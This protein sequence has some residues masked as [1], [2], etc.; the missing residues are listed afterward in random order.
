MALRRRV[1]SKHTERYTVWDNYE[2]HCK[3]LKEIGAT[4]EDLKPLKEAAEAV[5]AAEEQ[6]DRDKG[7][8]PLL[9]NTDLA[10][11][12]GPHTCVNG[13]VVQPPTRVARRWASSA[14]MKVTGGEQ[15][16]DALGTAYA[17]LAGLWALKAWGD[18]RKDEVMQVV[19]GPGRLAELLPDLEA[20]AGSTDYDALAGDYSALM[21]FSKK[22][23]AAMEKY[24]TILASIR[25][26]LSD[27]STE[28]S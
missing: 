26:K 1:T 9:E 27:R 4:D 12:T 11:L 5:A 23:G 28:A 25:E 13:W 6:D 15:P 18:D 19:T 2:R 14:M 22:N 24:E 20:D 8:N 3:E 17:V 21:G 16:D 10:E 7:R